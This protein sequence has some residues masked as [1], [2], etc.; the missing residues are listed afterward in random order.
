MSLESR[1]AIGLRQ[2]GESSD[3]YI[4]HNYRFPIEAWGR[5]RSEKVPS[6]ATHTTQLQAWA[7]AAI[8]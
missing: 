4:L 3:H 7:Q 1:H 2:G 6:C 5:H 8:R